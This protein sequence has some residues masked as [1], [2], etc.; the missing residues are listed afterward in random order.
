MNKKVLILHGWQGSPYPHWQALTTDELTKEG[1]IVSFPNLPNK[2]L[3]VLN[4]WLSFLE[5]EFNSFKPDIVV[6]H[7]LASIL[8]FHF[9]KK[10]NIES[11]EKLMLVSP[12]SMNCEIKELKTFFPYPIIK[13]LRA[14][15]IIMV[16]STNDPYMSSDE[17][18]DL[19]NKL[20]IGLKILDNA[21]HINESSGYGE[22]SC[23]A[24]WIKREIK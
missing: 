20:N 19:Q 16:G 15:E 11:I 24:Q 9:I 5:K 10:F 2:N 1:Y 7:S 4:Q 8:W 22:L 21:G 13:D 18:M 12:V 23:A 6:C 17:I 3:P 14:K